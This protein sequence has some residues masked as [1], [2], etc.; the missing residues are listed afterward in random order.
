MR[1][2]RREQAMKR[3]ATLG[4]VVAAFA[5]A[6]AVAAAENDVQVKPQVTAQVVDVQIAKV[7]RAQVAVSVQRHLVQVA[8]A[9]RFSLLTRLQI[10]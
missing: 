4:A 6:P 8:H 9:K 5:V 10:R 2:R 3:I 1:T 7:Q